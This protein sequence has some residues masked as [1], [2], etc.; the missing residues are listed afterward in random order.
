M[1]TSKETMYVTQKLMQSGIQDTTAWFDSKTEEQII[2]YMNACKEYDDT[3]SFAEKRAA[4][5]ETLTKYERRHGNEPY[6]PSDKVTV[7]RVG[8]VGRA[9]SSD[10]LDWGLDHNVKMADFNQ[11][12]V[13]AD[14]IT[15][16]NYM[17]YGLQ[18]FDQDVLIPP[19][20]K[21]AAG[22]FRGCKNMHSTIVAPSCLKDYF[23]DEKGLD[24][25]WYD[26]E[27]EYAIRKYQ[28]V[29]KPVGID[30]TLEMVHRNFK[31]KDPEWTEDLKLK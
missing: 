9:P 18:S 27:C 6:T 21:S 1:L 24:I 17:F 19:T 23:K 30:Q 16:C 5:K 4:L 15:N 10:I 20:V 29:T 13:I 31:G 8:D 12:V 25:Y 28:L 14:G 11:P 3:T 22:M 7:A 2:E 26:N